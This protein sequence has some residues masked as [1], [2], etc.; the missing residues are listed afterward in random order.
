MT[1]RK[2]VTVPEVVPVDLD[3]VQDHPPGPQMLFDEWCGWMDEQWDSLIRSPQN[4]DTMTG[5][6]NTPRGETR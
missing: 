1:R 5:Q 2:R 3:A 4:G 6:P